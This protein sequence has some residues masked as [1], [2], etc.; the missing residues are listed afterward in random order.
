MVEMVLLSAGDS[1]LH[2]IY[3]ALMGGALI[4]VVSWV[5]M[6]RVLKAEEEERKE[7]EKLKED[8]KR[9]VRWA[10]TAAIH[11]KAENV[12]DICKDN[13]ALDKQVVQVSYE[14]DL[15]MN[16]ILKNLAKATE[17]QGKVNQMAEELSDG[18]RITT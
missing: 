12:R 14:A 6:L 1:T 7:A 17:L 18:E 5:I 11:K 8:Y 15:Q 13:Y 4:G 3:A 16:A 10:D 2:F 9:R